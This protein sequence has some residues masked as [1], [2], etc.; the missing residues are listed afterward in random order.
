MRWLM[1]L[2]NFF[3]GCTH[4]HTTWPHRDARGLVYICCVDCGKELPYS[5][6]RMSI[7]TAEERFAEQNVLAWKDFSG[8]PRKNPA[9]I[10]ATVLAFPARSVETR[11]A[12]GSFRGN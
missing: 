6:R 7:V 12:A 8:R 11:M 5:L 4:R 3:F 9:G 1:W 10:P 2:F